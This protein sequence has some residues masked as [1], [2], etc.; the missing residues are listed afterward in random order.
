MLNKEEKEGVPIQW[1][2][3]R[4]SEKKRKETKRERRSEEAI[5]VGQAIGEEEK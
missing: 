4:I 5:V 3:P 1:R 2:E